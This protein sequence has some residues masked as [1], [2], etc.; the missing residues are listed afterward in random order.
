MGEKELNNGIAY[1]CDTSLEN[2]KSQLMLAF[3]VQ[4]HLFIV[5][6]NIGILNKNPFIAKEL[7]TAAIF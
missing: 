5:I 4:Q 6:P 3:L 1:P 7:V 2:Q